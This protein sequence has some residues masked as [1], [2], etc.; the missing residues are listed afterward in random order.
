[1]EALIQGKSSPDCETEEDS[2]RGSEIMNHL[3]EE[4]Q[5]SFLGLGEHEGRSREAQAYI[6]TIKA[7]FYPLK[8][9][10]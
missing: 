7:H 5:I 1:M 10:W 9:V 8:K 2:A 4:N 3:T 6:G